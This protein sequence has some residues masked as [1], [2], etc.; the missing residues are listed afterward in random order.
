M[1]RSPLC[2]AI[3]PVCRAAPHDQLGRVSAELGRVP[4]V[5]LA[6]AGSSVPAGGEP[7]VD[8]WMI[9]GAAASP[10][11]LVARIAALRGSNAAGMNVSRMRTS[12][13]Q[14]VNANAS[15]I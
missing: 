10:V 11:S 8:Q 5:G 14:K 15:D 6:S 7:R 9:T 1:Q 12:A 2:E 4:A 3:R 13:T